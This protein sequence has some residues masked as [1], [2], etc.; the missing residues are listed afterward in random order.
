MAQLQRLAIAPSQFC[1]SK[2]LLTAQQWHYLTHVLRLQTGDRFIAMDGQGHWWL[3]S[4]LTG[5]APE[6]EILQPILVET[7]LPVAITLI[8]ALPKGNG[9][10]EVIHQAT[11][12]GVSCITPIISERTLLKPSPQRLE[13]WRRIAQE[14]TEQSERQFVPTIVEP[15]PV[16]KSL[17]LWQAQTSSSTARYICVTQDQPPHL[18]DCLVAWIEKNKMAERSLSDATLATLNQPLAAVATPP[19]RA[20]IAIALGPEGGWTAAEMDQAI[21][22]N[23]QPV[24]LGSRIL[25]AVTAPIVALSLI[26]AVYEGNP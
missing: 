21:A 10:D 25:R 14:A 12:L 16:L 20:M 3:A 1:D 9:F 22:A 15:I 19:P 2:I 13:R 7:E 26:A 17:Q 4:L 23:F 5:R 24:S 6:A 18:I 8:A 11:E